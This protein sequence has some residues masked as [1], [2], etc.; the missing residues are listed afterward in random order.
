MGSAR[1]PSSFA[2]DASHSLIVVS[3]DADAIRDPSGVNA[4]EKTKPSCPRKTASL[5]PLSASPCTCD[6]AAR[7]ASGQV[8]HSYENTNHGGRPP[9]RVDA[10][11]PGLDVHCTRAGGQLRKDQRFDADEFDRLSTRF[12]TGAGV[13]PHR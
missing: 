9:D 1:K 10:C 11:L 8:V 13:H 6:Q 4:T 7:T 5:S 2:F 12:D 3:A